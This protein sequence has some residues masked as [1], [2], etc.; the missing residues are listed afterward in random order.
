M[1][2][3]SSSETLVLTRVTRRNIPED[4]ILHSHRRE[5]LNY[6]VCLWWLIIWTNGFY[7]EWLVVRVDSPLVLVRMLSCMSGDVNHSCGEVL[8]MS[9][10]V[11]KFLVM[12]LLQLE[13]APFLW[14]SDV[15]MYALTRRSQNRKP[16]E[17]AS[18]LLVQSRLLFRALMVQHFICQSFNSIL[19]PF[20][21]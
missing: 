14:N 5:N 13:H 6:G 21:A 10:G 11:G 1:E 12:R 2:A 15:Y 7:R 4:A 9:Y 19:L 3:L 17:S 20:T 18:L 16:I 8:R